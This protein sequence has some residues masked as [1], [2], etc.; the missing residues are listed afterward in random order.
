MFRHDQPAGRPFRHAGIP[1]FPFLD[2]DTPHLRDVSE[3][4]YMRHVHQELHQLRDLN[5]HLT[6][7]CFD[8]DRNKTFA[9]DI[10][11]RLK[12]L[13]KAH[14]YWDTV[15][16]DIPLELSESF[17]SGGGEGPIRPPSLGKGPL[18]PSVLAQNDGPYKDTHLVW[19][20]FRC[21]HRNDRRYKWTVYLSR[22]LLTF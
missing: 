13:G 4:R 16:A 12:H 17:G 18:D 22:T 1:G 11:W 10:E 20:P 19:A 21:F 15:L 3:L 14:D 2:L 8:N 7:T 9:D 5:D 6:K